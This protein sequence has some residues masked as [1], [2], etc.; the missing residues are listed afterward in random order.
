MNTYS[1]AP[2]LQQILKKVPYFKSSKD[3]LHILIFELLKEKNQTVANN[4]STP[5]RSPA[6]FKMPMCT[7]EYSAVLN[8]ESFPKPDQV[9][10]PQSPCNLDTTYPTP[11]A[12]TLRQ[13]S[14][15]PSQALL[16]NPKAST[17]FIVNTAF[18]SCRK[19]AVSF[20]SPSCCSNVER[21][22][23]RLTSPQ[24]PVCDRNQF[25]TNF[26][27]RPSEKLMVHTTPAFILQSYFCWN[28]SPTFNWVLKQL[29]LP[30]STL[31]PKAF[32]AFYS[33]STSS[34]SSP[35]S[36]LYDPRSLS[37]TKANADIFRLLLPKNLYPKEIL[38]SKLQYVR[39][40]KGRL[41]GQ[42]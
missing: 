31:I 25:F 26:R 30:R 21:S 28:D 33:C 4:R 42:S 5:Q 41:P 3:L 12:P 20:F 27:K 23:P 32:V 10:C 24:G 11:K 29:H 13:A 35:L 6:Q 34:E 2:D 16:S 38:H 17:V 37:Q 39:Q 15:F 18:V 36:L 22:I 19:N 9:S 1:S 40:T 7:N 14:F 8:R